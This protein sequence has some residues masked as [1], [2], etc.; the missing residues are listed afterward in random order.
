MQVMKY[1]HSSHMLDPV[2]GMWFLFELVGLLARGS[3]SLL[4]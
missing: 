2:T 3:S 1:C 4:E